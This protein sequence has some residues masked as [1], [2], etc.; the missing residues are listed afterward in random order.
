M[1]ETIHVGMPKA[2]PM[3]IWIRPNALNKVGSV[4]LFLRLLAKSAYYERKKSPNDNA[5]REGLPVA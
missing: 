4:I 5:Q 3:T 1:S 2:R